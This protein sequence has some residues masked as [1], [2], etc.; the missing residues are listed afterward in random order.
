M[1]GTINVERDMRKIVMLMFFAVFCG[2]LFGDAFRGVRKEIR[3][4][5]GIEKRTQQ[6]VLMQKEYLPVITEPSEGSEVACPFTI[7]GTCVEGADAVE[8]KFDGQ[9]WVKAEGGDSWEYTV[10]TLAP[11]TY[12]VRVRAL[13]G[14]NMTKEST[15]TFIVGDPSAPE[16]SL[17]AGPGTD[18]ATNAPFTVTLSA[19]EN[20]GY[21][22]T[23]GTVWVAF[24]AGT[25]EVFI[26]HSVTLSFFGKDL[27]NNTG[28]TQSIAYTVVYISWI[29]T[30]GGAGSEWLRCVQQTADGGYFSAGYTTSASAGGY[31]CFLLKT[32]AYGN[33]VWSKTYGGT[34]N[35]S[36]LDGQQTSD[37]GYVV[38]G[39]TLSQGNGKSDF[40][41]MRL[42]SGGNI[43]WQKTYGGAD[44][45][46][47]TG[48]E[49]TADGGFIIVGSTKSFGAGQEDV[50]LVKTDS[51]GNVVWAHT[52]GTAGAETAYSVHQN[53]DNGYIIGGNFGGGTLS[54]AYLIRTDD[55]GGLLWERVFGGSA[56]EWAQSVLQTSDGGFAFSG[57]T[58]SWGAGNSDV[59]LIKTDSSG[60]GVWT[61][62]YGSTD[63]DSGFAVRETPDH[64]FAIGGTTYSYGAG[65][66]DAYLVRVG[67]D[68]QFLWQKTYGGSPGD[69]SYNM[70]LTADGGF[71]LSGWSSSFGVGNGFLIK[72][73][74]SGTAP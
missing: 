49:Q 1:S 69:S 13:Y 68:G 30:F 23:N 74:P 27:S 21:W 58:Y 34:N 60:N 67:Q 11:G 18:L 66:C 48:V 15:R 22:S 31:D 55:S 32:D 63:Y 37:G 19:G 47:A 73:D 59:Y 12:T 39:G 71:A 43:L 52:F 44:E 54:D 72:T 42:D 35:D 8:I 57:D 9:P 7:G 46:Y 5:R 62:T 10:D 4:E 25:T 36:I 40:L 24:P 65:D 28:P 3:Q 26:D 70:T 51:T 61:N 56:I 33:M 2:C 17:T 29:K 45:D 41:L 20:N 6:D 16:V 64:G 50:Y 53:T 14:K 38:A